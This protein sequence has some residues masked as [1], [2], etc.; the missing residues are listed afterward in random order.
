MPKNELK[1]SHV[2]GADFSSKVYTGFIECGLYSHRHKGEGHVFTKSW[3][4]R[5]MV[6]GLR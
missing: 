2:F 1:A 5:D 4:K 6:V 3:Q